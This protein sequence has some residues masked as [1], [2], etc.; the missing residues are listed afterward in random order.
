VSTAKP[1]LVKGDG[2]IKKPGLL[3][4]VLKKVTEAIVVHKPKGGREW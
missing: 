3:T 1:A 4:K 2:A